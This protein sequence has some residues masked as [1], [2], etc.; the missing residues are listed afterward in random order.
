MIYLLRQINF[1]NLKIVTNNI[2]L[3]NKNSDFL[4][5]FKSFDFLMF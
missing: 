2:C 1:E 3:L 5:T 4:R